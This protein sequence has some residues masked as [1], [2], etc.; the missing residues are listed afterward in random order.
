MN[1]TWANSETKQLIRHGITYWA[2]QLLGVRNV[3]NVFTLPSKDALC[4]NTFRESW[5]NCSLFGVER[6]KKIWKEIDRSSGIYVFNCSLRD[7]IKQNTQLRGDHFD[8][9]F[10]DFTGAA[11]ET[12]VKVVTDWVSNEN[13]VHRGKKSIVAVTFNGSDRRY[14]TG[15][16]VKKIGK[17]VHF[18]EEEKPFYNSE[19][20]ANLVMDE[21]QNAVKRIRVLSLL[22]CEDYQSQ[23]DSQLMYFFILVVEKY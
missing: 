18:D 21:I 7:Y 20:S 22:H 14:G 6:V 9:A 2:D 15:R 12:N 23:E 17:Q 1:A 10:F 5:P 19:T 8:V 13:V 4:A 3:K 11:S 16:I